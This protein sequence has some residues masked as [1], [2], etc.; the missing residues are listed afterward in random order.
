MISRHCTISALLLII[1]FGLNENILVDAASTILGTVQRRSGGISTGVDA[2]VTC[3]DE[4]D[5]YEDNHMASGFTSSGSFSLTYTKKTNVW[6]NP[7]RGWDCSPGDNP[8]IYCYVGR[9]NFA[10]PDIFPYRTGIQQNWNQDDD[11]DLHAIT[12]YPDRRQSWCANTCGPAGIDQF[13]PDFEFKEEC[14]QH[15]CCY[16][17]CGETQS[18]CDDEFYDLMLSRCREVYGDSTLMKQCY[19]RA[20]L[21]YEAVVV[22]GT[23]LFGCKEQRELNGDNDG[24]ENHGNSSHVLLPQK[25]P[26]DDGYVTLVDKRSKVTKI[27]AVAVAILILGVL[28]VNCFLRRSRQSATDNNSFI[29]KDRNNLIVARGEA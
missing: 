5:L 21:Y 12:V 11:L 16:T 14:R 20:Y 9:R 17:D 15:D 26:Q 2:I 3:F 25:F 29:K 18:T 23:N 8:D 7:C 1:S 4:D 28:V 13:V 22:G 24:A 10:S 27:V 19:A 6:Y